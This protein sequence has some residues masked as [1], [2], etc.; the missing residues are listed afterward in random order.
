EERVLAAHPVAH[1]SEQECAKRTDQE[2]G[3]EQRNRAQQGR[4]RV[5]LF[6]E[7]DRQDR[8]QAPENIEV[9]PLDDVSHCRG[10]D[11]APEVLGDLCHGCPSF[12]LS[13]NTSQQAGWVVEWFQMSPRTTCPM[14]AGRSG[15]FY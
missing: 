14:L 13:R 8:G 12:V 7:L 3:G 10:D 5:A 4:N 9:I 6:E 15:P 2:S 11:H 1:P